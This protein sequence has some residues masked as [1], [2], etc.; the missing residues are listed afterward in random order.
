MNMNHSKQKIFTKIKAVFCD[1][2]TRICFVFLGSSKQTWEAPVSFGVSGRK[3]LKERWIM[4]REENQLDVTEC[5]IALMIGST[6]F[7]HFY[8]HHQELENVCVLLL[9]MVWSAWLLVV[10]GQVPTTH[11]VQHPST[12]TH[13][14]LLCTWPSTTSNRALHTIGGNNTHIVS[15]S[16]WWA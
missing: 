12:W 1:L 13:S 6:C 14:L 2:V 10:E 9:P 5:F 16:W 4:R 8:A 15:S 3:Y 11:V 7:G